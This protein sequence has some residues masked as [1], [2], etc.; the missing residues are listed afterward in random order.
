MN[1]LLTSGDVYSF[2]IHTVYD[3]CKTPMK[4]NFRQGEARR[5]ML[6]ATGVRLQNAF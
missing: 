3:K 2:L 5:F 1:I 6:Y 4:L